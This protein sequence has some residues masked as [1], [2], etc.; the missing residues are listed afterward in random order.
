MLVVL[1]QKSGH[2]VAQRI[3][4]EFLVYTVTPENRERV[5]LEVSERI[6]KSDG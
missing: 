3:R 5:V 1:H 6:N 4:R 2:P